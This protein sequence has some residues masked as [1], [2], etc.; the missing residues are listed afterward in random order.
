MKTSRSGMSFFLSALIDFVP[1]PLANRF[2]LTTVEVRRRAGRW[3]KCVGELALVLGGDE[4]GDDLSDR[5]RRVVSGEEGGD[6]KV[7]NVEKDGVRVWWCGLREVEVDMV[8]RGRPVWPEGGDV[9]EG[10]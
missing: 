9:G 7:D 6:E 8:E 1:T 3:S 5:G 4:G 2:H 10:K